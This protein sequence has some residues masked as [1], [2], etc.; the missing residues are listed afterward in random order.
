LDGD[1]VEAVAALKREPGR[2]LQVHGSIE[3]TQALH[4]AGLVDR[5]HLTILP[6]VLRGGRGLFEGEL[7]PMKLRLE[8]ATTTPTGVQLVT[9]VPDGAVVQ[10]HF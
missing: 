7:P 1:L 9:L 3:L 4:S 5:H 2:E 6:I 10:G 8:G